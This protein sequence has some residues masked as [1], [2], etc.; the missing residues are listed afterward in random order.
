MTVVEAVRAE[1]DA[2]PEVAASPLATV[3]LDLAQRLDAGPGDRTAVALS[4]ELRLVLAE[5]HAHANTDVGGEVEQFL[6]RV[7]TPAFR[8]PGD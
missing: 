4:R 1:L 2:L 7:S 5:L 3:L 8:K 6:R